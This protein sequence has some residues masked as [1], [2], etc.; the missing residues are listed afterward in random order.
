[1]QT[2]LKSHELKFRSPEQKEHKMAA[3]G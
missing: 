3:K 2:E 1:M